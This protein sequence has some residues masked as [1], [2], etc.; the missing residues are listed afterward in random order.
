M[1]TTFWNNQQRL[2]TASGFT[3]IE[4]MITI[5]VLGILAA[6]AYP[7]YTKYVR[8]SR[9]SDATIAISQIAAREEKFLTECGVYSANFNG[10]ILDANAGTRCTGL[11]IGPIAGT[12]TTLDGYYTMTIALK[13]GP[14]PLNAAGGGGYTITAVPASNQVADTAYCAT[15]TLDET[16]KRT[17]TGT[18]GNMTTGGKCWKR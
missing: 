13:A 10:V 8:E 15:F 18:D 1:R 6:I 7:N 3:L 11:G 2:P 4:L 16:G 14:P 9:R 5:V 17:A 12:Y